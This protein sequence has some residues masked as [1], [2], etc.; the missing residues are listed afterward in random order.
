M[1]CNRHVRRDETFCAARQSKRWTRFHGKSCKT[2][3]NAELRS[4]LVHLAW[5]W[6]FFELNSHFRQ[7]RTALRF[8]P[9]DWL[10]F[11]RTATHLVTLIWSTISTVPRWRY[12][13]NSMSLPINPEPRPSM[14]AYMMLLFVTRYVPQSILNFSVTWHESGP[15]YLKTSQWDKEREVLRDGSYHHV[16]IASHFSPPALSRVFICASR[17]LDFIPSLSYELQQRRV[18]A[19]LIWFIIR[20]A[21]WLSLAPLR[22]NAR[23]FENDKRFAKAQAL[24]IW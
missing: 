21:R 20:L 9:Q 5:S 12:P 15:P 6:L 11:S 10:A 18:L 7:F 8:A 1:Q 13:V 19:I 23:S 3:Q 22:V 16:I 4:F 24:W 2:P 14:A 17:I